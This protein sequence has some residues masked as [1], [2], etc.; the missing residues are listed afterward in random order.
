MMRKNLHPVLGQSW[1]PHH[2]RFK[3][4]MI[5]GYPHKN[6]K[7]IGRKQK[8]FWHTNSCNRNFDQ[9]EMGPLKS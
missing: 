8:N 9:V 3:R 7:N 6:F 4:V 1:H 5:G 2:K